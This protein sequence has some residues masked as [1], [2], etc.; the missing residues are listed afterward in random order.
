MR[1][2]TEMPR[3]ADDTHAARVDAIQSHKK[4]YVVS[5]GDAWPRVR[6][7]SYK[8]RETIGPNLSR[9]PSFRLL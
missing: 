1:N 9:M 6:D 8:D 5:Y 7:G 4:H 3:V 2:V